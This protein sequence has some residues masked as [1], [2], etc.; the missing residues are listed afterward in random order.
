[1]AQRPLAS[2][3][4]TARG[5][6]EGGCADP[7]PLPPSLP[8]SPSHHPVTKEARGACW[9]RTT[10]S[11]CVGQSRSPQALAQVCDTPTQPCRPRAGPRPPVPISLRC[12]RCAVCAVLLPDLP[13]RRHPSTG[14]AASPPGTHKGQE[15]CR[16]SKQMLPLLP[17]FN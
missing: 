8:P 2:E 6:Q 17:S 9:T 16:S 10:L 1:M 5:S 7:L 4:N 15:V 13:G 12:S 11:L 3:D 14:R